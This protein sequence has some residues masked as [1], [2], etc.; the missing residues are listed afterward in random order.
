V[1]AGLVDFALGSDTGGSV[2]APASYCGLFGHR[3]TWGRA[4]LAGARAFARSY[5]TAGWFARDADLLARVGA[6]L[7][8]APPGDP[9][10]PGG[11]ALAPPGA[12]GQPPAP[13]AFRPLLPRDAWAL[14]DPDTAAALTGRLAAAAPAVAAALGAA[15]AELESL[16]AGAGPG[17][18]A[19]ADW[20]E[21]FRVAQAGEIWA[22]LGG[23]VA[24]ARPAF[25]P[26]IAE[27]FAMAAAITPQQ[28]AA[29]AAQRA[30]VRAHVLALLG[31]D[32]LLLVPTM[33][34]PAPVCGTAGPALDGWRRR[35]LAGLCVA[36]L[37]GLPQLSLP[38]AAVGGAPVGL[39]IIGPPG[40]DEALLAAGARLARAL[41]IG[42]AAGR[43]PVASEV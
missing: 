15:P 32:G 40:S 38:A 10:A 12:V 1:A 29:A 34:G 36:G 8:A 41:G 25:G 17:L 20:A 18:G 5:D 30:A 21:A 3:P 16:A 6:V 42:P 7:L 19:L 43:P 13:A 9:L 28:R 26:G 37:A 33:P 27:R 2:R 11:G 31:A 39:S 35:A 24:A 22:E 23:W 4:S 14:A